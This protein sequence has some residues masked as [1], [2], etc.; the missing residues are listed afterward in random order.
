MHGEVTYT[1]RTMNGM[2][3]MVSNVSLCTVE[4][5]VT[6][7]Q[8]ELGEIVRFGPNSLSFNTSKAVSDIY[9]VRAN[10]RKSDGY[11]SMSPSRF[12]P[13]TLTA[14]SK[15]IHTFKRRILAQA[16]SDQNIKE[17]EGRIQQNISSFLDILATNTES[18]SEWSSPK[19]ISQICD[20]LAFDVITDLSYGNDLDMLNSPQMRWFPSV[21]R[22]ISQR[23]LIVCPFSASQFKT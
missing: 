18:E 10:V 11:A 8:F 3:N 19:D 7:S 9:A 2:S 21:V 14:I 16:F 1:Q 4:P 6:W 13:N 12:T 22:K 23:S 5:R 15:D 17:M 20:W